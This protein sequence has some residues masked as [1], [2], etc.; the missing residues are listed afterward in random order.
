MVRDID[1][2]ALWSLS[3][4]REVLG[5][6]FKECETG[7]AGKAEP[8]AEYRYRARRRSRRSDKVASC[9]QQKIEALSDRRGCLDNV[10]EDAGKIRFGT[11]GRF[12][13]Q[14]DIMAVLYWH[15][16]ALIHP[17]RTGQSGTD[18]SCPRGM[19]LLFS[20]HVWQKKGISRWMIY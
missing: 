13:L 8:L 18:L 14:A 2:R 20:M 11:S 6:G 3:D 1:P 10:I 12:T 9:K 5:E 7:L 19:R 17:G 4:V 16:M 15:E